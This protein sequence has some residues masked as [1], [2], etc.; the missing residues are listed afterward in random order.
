MQS[1]P[2][3]P[4]VGSKSFTQFRQAGGNSSD[5]Q[6][7]VVS[8]ISGLL[9]VC[10][11]TAVARFVITEFIRP[12]INLKFWRTLSHICQKFCERIAPA[13]ANSYPLSSIKRIRWTIWIRASLNHVCPRLVSAINRLSSHKSTVS[14]FCFRSS[15]LLKTS[16]RLRVSGAKARVPCDER[17]STITLTSASGFTFSIWPDIRVGGFDYDCSSKS[18]S[19]RTRFEWHNGSGSLLS[20]VAASGHNRMS[21]RF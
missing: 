7:E 8:Q 14:C 10:R 9:L 15:F 13:F 18:T 5:R 17:I 3:T 1:S 6:H 20:Q 16:A 2:N 4:L 19:G 21:L 12:T 11:P